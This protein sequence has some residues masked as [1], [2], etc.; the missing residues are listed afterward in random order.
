MVQPYAAFRHRWFTG[1]RFTTLAG[2]EG[3]EISLGDADAAATA[4]QS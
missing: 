3:V 2:K 4:G 1:R